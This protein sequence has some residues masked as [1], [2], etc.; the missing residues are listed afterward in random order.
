MTVSAFVSSTFEDLQHHRTHVISVLRKSGIAVDPMEDW[1]ADRSAPKVFSP[2]RV[3]DHNL[4]VLLVAFRRGH[5]PEGELQSITQLEYRAAVAAGLDMLV[6]LLAE[7]APWPRRF[8]ELNSDPELVRWRTELMERVGVGFFNERPESIEIGAAIA[9]WLG[10]RPSPDSAAKDAVEIAG[11]WRLDSRIVVG[12][13]VGSTVVR[14][15]AF[16]L[17]QPELPTILELDR[18]EIRHPASVSSLLGQTRDLI[19]MVLEREAL[20]AHQL[21]GIGV[22]AP[23]QVDMKIG[24]LEFGP[25]L[26]LRGVPF[27]S[28]LSDAFMSV[29]VRVDN[30]AR[31][32]TRAELRLGVGRMVNSFA[33][34]FIGTGVGSGLVLGGHIYNGENMC[35]GEI[36]HT[37]INFEGP[38]CKCGRRGCLEVYIN[39]PA[40]ARRAAKKVTDCQLDGRPTLLSEVAQ[41]DLDSEAVAD[42]VGKGDQAAREVVTETSQLLGE[43]L[44]NYLNAFDLGTIVLGGGVMDGL[45]QYMI[46]DIQRKVR[47]DALDQVKFRVTRVHHMATGAMI[48][49]ALLFHPDEKWLGGE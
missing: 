16:D 47:D 44:A 40:I 10:R 48:G 1:S 25:G 29:P 5:I 15:A 2:E 30:D 36:G 45:F 18:A 17:A 9:R 35:A 43:G 28:H 37:T 14:A 20:S 21:A 11:R 42:A 19:A 3:R 26:G 39:G 31:C 22:A 33:C 4:C 13:D 12:V 8:D 34:I 6:F 49:A 38:L 32:A 46:D 41:S 27:A 24:S 23:G 7:D